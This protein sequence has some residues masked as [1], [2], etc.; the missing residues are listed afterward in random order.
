MCEPCRT[1]QVGPVSS[2]PS[3]VLPPPSGDMTLSHLCTHCPLLSAH[4]TQLWGY[5]LRSAASHTQRYTHPI[6]QSCTQSAR[7]IT[8]SS[9]VSPTVT[10]AGLPSPHTV[11][12]P[13]SH[14]HS[15]PA[16]PHTLK[17]ACPVSPAGPCPTELHTSGTRAH[18]HAHAHPFCN[19]IRHA[20][21]FA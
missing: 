5:K 15:R 14:T 11:H 19:N 4:P 6:T 9:T 21:S 16:A 7:P 12:T 10:V 20:I 1:G 2:S 13:P 3:P 8:H 18:T 17:H